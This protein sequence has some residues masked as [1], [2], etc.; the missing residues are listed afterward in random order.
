[1]YSYTNHRFQSRYGCSFARRRLRPGVGSRIIY[2][3]CVKSFGVLPPSPELICENSTGSE[4]LTL[5]DLPFEL[6][7][8]IAS[9]LDSFRYTIFIK[10]STFLKN[11]IINTILLYSLCHLAITNRLFRDVTCSLLPNRGLVSMQWHKTLQGWRI[12]HNVYIDIYIH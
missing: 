3:S 12:S 9:Y 8:T 6:L 4:G 11:M 10:N 1:M 7:R 2:S 5:S